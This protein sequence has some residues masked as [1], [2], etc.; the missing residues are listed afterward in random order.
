MMTEKANL[1]TMKLTPLSQGFAGPWSALKS[2]IGI[3]TTKIWSILSQPSTH[4]LTLA[5]VAA[6]CRSLGHS[7]IGVQ[8]VP[9]NQI[10]GSASQG[11]SQDF[12]LNFRPQRANVK[13]R[14]RGIVT[15]RQRGVK[16]PPVVLIQVGNIYFVEDG[17]HRISVAHAWGEPEI[18]AEVTV[19]QVAGALPWEA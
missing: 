13:E 19:W 7:Y 14:C 1:I 8:Q 17:H 18:E 10:M 9:L 11:R 3:Q 12:D 4:L 2:G 5:E 15:A 6:S 16:L